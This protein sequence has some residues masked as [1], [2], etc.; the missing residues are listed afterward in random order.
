VLA[1]HQRLYEESLGILRSFTP[2]DLEQKCE[3]P[4]GSRITVWKWLRAMTE[5]EA[6]HRGQLYW[7]LAELGVPTPPLYGLTSEEVH[8]RAG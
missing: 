4:D 3:T 8:S 7:M 6:H 1:F 2:A 5:H